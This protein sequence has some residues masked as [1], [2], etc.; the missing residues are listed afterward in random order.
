MS[1]DATP[2]AELTFAKPILYV[3]AEHSP[4]Y[5]LW[6]EKGCRN[7]SVCHVDFHCDMRGL[8]IDRRHGRA[9]FVWQSDPFMNRLDS[10]SFLAHAVMNGF[11][12]NLRWVHDVFGGRD[13]DHLYCVKYETDFSAL[14]FHVM[15]GGRWV[16]LNFTEQTFADWGGPQPGEYLSLDWDA[17]AFA[18][19]EEAHIR[20]LMAE[21]LDRDFSPEGI[22]VAHSP[23]YCHP[24][25][26]LFDEFIMRLEE[27]F[28][29]LAVRLPD[30]LLPP[31]LSSR[32]WK[33][34]HQLEHF[35]LRKMRRRGIY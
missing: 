24:E 31:Q 8:L 11:V 29:T 17:L 25:Q 3:A 27:K 7:L 26:A 23:E 15:P 19:Y 14:P 32:S 34:Y 13:Y 35:V 4:L 5:D 9:R 22:F 16:P 1:Q 6:Q 12:T 2:I 21:I 33:V 10:G 20:R 28:K 18:D 30:K